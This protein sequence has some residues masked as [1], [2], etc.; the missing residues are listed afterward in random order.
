MY[1]LRTDI[2]VQITESY[3]TLFRAVKVPGTK[4]P[5]RLPRKRRILA[6]LPPLPTPAK[7]EVVTLFVRT[8]AF[9]AISKASSVLSHRQFHELWR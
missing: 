4:S 2:I 3:I 7:A 1:V 5:T 6:V 8:L 9:A